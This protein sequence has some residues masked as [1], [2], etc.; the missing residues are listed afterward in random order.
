M[1]GRARSTSNCKGYWTSK[2]IA[3]AAWREEYVPFGFSN[4]QSLVGQIR[5]FAAQGGGQ[6]IVVLTVVGNSIPDFMREFA[7]QGIKATDIPVL[8]LDMVEADLEGLNTA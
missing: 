6:P 4:F 5:A 3:P 7:N 2:G 8:G 1:S